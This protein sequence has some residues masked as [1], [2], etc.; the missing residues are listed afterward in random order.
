MKKKLAALLLILGLPLMSA[1]G[2]TVT[3]WKLA[4][5]PLFS[6]DATFI[7]VDLEFAN[8]HEFVLPLGKL[9]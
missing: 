3:E 6:H 9:F 8:G 4:F 2:C 1:G 5:G 7:G